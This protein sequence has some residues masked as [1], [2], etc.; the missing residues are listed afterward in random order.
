V[1]VLILGVTGSIGHAI[2]HFFQDNQYDVWGT[3]RDER[4]LA[5]FPIQSHTKLIHGV[6]V[7]HQSNLI[8]VF[9]KVRPAVVINCTGIIKQLGSANDPAVV[10]PLN[11][12]FPHQLSDICSI[13]NARL[14][15]VS[16]DCVFSGKK[17][18][19]L[20]TDMSDAED[21]YGKSKFMGEISEK[22]HVVTLR[23]ST[24]GHELNTK[25]ALLEWFLSQKN[26]V[27]GYANAIYSGVPT[28]ELASVI[29]DFVLPNRDLA[30]L[31]HVASQPIPKYHLLQLIAK[32]YS[33][34]INIKLDETVCV[35][36]SLSAARFQEQTGYVPAEWPMLVE[37]LYQSRQFIGAV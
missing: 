18:N 7:L 10:L 37:K 25:Y 29:R 32:R 27:N 26:S 8:R 13:L 17:G 30:G 2:W 21:L 22:P 28:L 20:E 31:Y 35:D 34:A 9:E 4:M 15:Q 33:K 5:Y 24:I 14:I 23:T 11:A 6:D 36:R 19:Y 12:I 1:R 16:T 3:L